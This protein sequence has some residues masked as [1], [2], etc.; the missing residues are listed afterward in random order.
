VISIAAGLV[1]VVSCSQATVASS[2]GLVGAHDLALVGDRLFVTSTDRDELKVLNL[3]P[4]TRSAGEREFMRAPNPLESLSVPV[5]SRPSTLAHDVHYADLAPAGGGIVPLGREVSGPWVYAM[6]AGGAEFSVVAA[7]RDQLFEVKLDDEKHT[8]LR[9]PTTEPVTALAAWSNAGQ[10]C[11]LAAPFCAGTLE[12]VEGICMAPKAFSR[13]F[14]AT[15]NGEDTTLRS[16]DLPDRLSEL[17]ALEV[18]QLTNQALVGT[19][20]GE[21]VIDIQVVP[22]IPGQTICSDPG[23]QCLILA[24]RSGQG[25]AGRALIYDL[26]TREQLDLGFPAPVRQLAVHAGAFGPTGYLAPGRRIWGVLSEE[27]CGGPDCSGLIAVDSI[28]AQVVL[29]VRDTVQSCPTDGGVSAYDCSPHS[30]C[31]AFNGD[32][33]RSCHFE[34][35][36]LPILVGG[37]LPTG[38]ALAS[39]GQLL[40]PPPLSSGLA[41]TPLA[42]LGVAST[43]NGSLLFFDAANNSQIDTDS[44]GPFAT[45]VNLFKP[46]AILQPMCRTGAVGADG[47]RACE[48]SETP[49][50]SLADDCYIPGPLIDANGN[51]ITLVDGAWG[52]ENIEVVVNGLIPGL[53]GGQTFDSDGDAFPTGF[54]ARAQ[55][56]DTIIAATPSGPCRIP[57]TSITADA[58]HSSAFATCS[59]RTSFAVR[60]GDSN[61]YVLT[62]TIHG[63]LGRSGPDQTFNGYTNYVVRYVDY[64]PYRPTIR[65]TFGPR[66]QGIGEDYVW[67]I[68][69]A[70]HFAPFLSQISVEVGCLTSLAGSVAFDTERQRVFVAYPSAPGIMDFN[71]NSAARGVTSANAL[72]YH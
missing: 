52:T 38:L 7:G 10:A 62:A 42:V 58:V 16:I 19:F 13:V 67:E 29:D 32:G 14:F 1:I 5:L 61:P 50:A 49:C 12:C 51:G 23:K 11:G 22:G 68:S 69:V 9:V 66:H 35:P 31:G 59:G 27:T 57:V 2:A 41:P 44:A 47:A 65:L 18:K 24:T 39:G 64:D 25:R 55:L 30:E 6:R 60:A 20:A 72:C 34:A 46:G 70:S 37:S 71:P 17:K 36:M 21:V 40:L 8:P 48:L 53:V 4:S 56:G 45:S 33:L 63:F 3:T 28:T 15:S 54:S 26:Q 43:S